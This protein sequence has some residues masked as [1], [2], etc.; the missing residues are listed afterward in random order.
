MFKLKNYF[1]IILF[2]ISF[3]FAETNNDWQKIN[4]SIY[5]ISN[6]YQKGKAREVLRAY[7]QSRGAYIDSL[8]KT[9]QLINNYQ[10]SKDQI[11]EVLPYAIASAYRLSIVTRKMVNSEM[12]Y[13]YEQ[14]EYYK[15]V[16][17]LI[18]K[19]L[20][21]ISN[22]RLDKHLELS[23]AYYSHLYYARALNNLGLSYSLTKG[24]LWKGYLVYMP[25]DILLIMDSVEDDL[26]HYKFL[27]KV[28]EKKDVEL[29]VE[30]IINGIQPDSNLDLTIKL[31]YYL[32]DKSKLK[33]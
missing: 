9:L 23:V 7:K 1:L 30:N 22:L 4:R 24:I 31:S 19:T 25:A 20:A 13:L 3:V 5:R 2:I 12:V 33:K 17:D 11:Y 15:Q 26:L 14:I 6:A 32:N 21:L 8:T 16:N 28:S 10:I 29:A 27:N 18:S